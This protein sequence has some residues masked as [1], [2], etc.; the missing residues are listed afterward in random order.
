MGGSVY[1]IVDGGSKK[2][3]IDGLWKLRLSSWREPSSGEIP[4]YPPFSTKE[5]IARPRGKTE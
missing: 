5:I 3:A 1:I 2:L 4:K